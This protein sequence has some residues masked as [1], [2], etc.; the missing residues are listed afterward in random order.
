[1]EREV[2][3]CTIFVHLSTISSILRNIHLKFCNSYLSRDNFEK[4]I[5]LISQ[6]KIVLDLSKPYK[7]LAKNSMEFFW[8]DHSF[9]NG[10]LLARMTFIEE[11]YLS[12][13]QKPQKKYKK[14]LKPIQ[15]IGTLKIYMSHDLQEKNHPF[16]KLVGKIATFHQYCRKF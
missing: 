9:T 6:K 11:I 1:M 15:K 2:F 10:W 3:S 8:V 5:H 4:F 12:H 7:I 16:Q 13:I 14:N